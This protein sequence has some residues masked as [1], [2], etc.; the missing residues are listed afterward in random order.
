MSRSAQLPWGER[1]SVLL[2]HRASAM[3]CASIVF[4]VAIQWLFCN[5]IF[6]GAALRPMLQS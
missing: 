4:V 6:G 2:G 3:L 5:T 1:L